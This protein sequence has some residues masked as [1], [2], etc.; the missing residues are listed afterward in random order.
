M[1]KM[2]LAA[3]MPLALLAAGC[4]TV[5]D[6]PSSAMLVAGVEATEAATRSRCPRS[7]L[8]LSALLGARTGFDI[9]YRARLS[10]ADVVRVDDA[11]ALTDAV[12]GLV[13]API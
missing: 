2:L 12:C 10:P 1:K 7:A 9:I 5:T 4:A 3:A 13:S 11:R 6:G 8:E